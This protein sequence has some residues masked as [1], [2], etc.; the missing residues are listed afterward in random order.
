MKI[1]QSL[2]AAGRPLATLALSSLV[3]ALAACA[4]TQAGT[5]PPAPPP[6]T[7][8]APQTATLAETHEHVGRVEA[9][10]QVDI[11]PRVAGQIVD[12]AFAEGAHVAKGD[13][14]VR[15]DPRPYAA[16]VERARAALVKAQ[17]EAALA[18]LEAQRAHKLEAMAAMSKEEAQRR[19][20]NAEV[21]AAQVRAAAAAVASAQL[22]LEFTTVRAP[23]AGRVG[24]ADVSVGN[25]VTP[26]PG[27]RPITTLVSGGTVYVAFDVND[28]LA[29]RVLQATTDKSARPR[30]LLAT[31]D[32]APLPG[33]AELAFADNRVGA[34]TGTLR[35][36]A[37]TAAL[38]QLPPG[39]FVRV[40]LAFDNAAPALLIDD[41][42]VGV[43]QDKRFVLVVGADGK[44]A[45]R[46]VELGARHGEQRVVR[47]GIDAGDRVIVD[48]LAY[49]RPGMTVTPQEAQQAGA[50]QDK[51]AALTREQSK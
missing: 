47:R 34:G 24:R 25:L 35:L 42:A 10:Q 6:V 13:V 48:G 5:A 15:L 14:L 7:V 30:V 12:I 26:D 2:S 9:I 33:T 23:I 1:R 45:Y 38:P 11:R 50:P 37:R 32:G 21:A 18:V 29:A 41:R 17:A 51:H 8:A 22:D 16:A 4:P 31:A 40:T 27:A 19:Q 20:A 46:P 44:V 43:D 39:A 36:R 3:A 49:A 28:A